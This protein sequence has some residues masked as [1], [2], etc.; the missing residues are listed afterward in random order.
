MNNEEVVK[1][2]S[3]SQEGKKV[4][5]EIIFELARALNLWIRDRESFHKEIE[6]SNL[7]SNT[8]N[9]PQDFKEEI[10]R[11]IDNNENCIHQLYHTLHSTKLTRELSDIIRKCENL[12]CL[13]GELIPVIND[14][15]YEYINSNIDVFF[16]VIDS[17]FGCHKFNEDCFKNILFTRISNF[18]KSFTA[19]IYQFPIVVFNLDREIT[20][21]DNVKLIPLDPLSLKLEEIST[22]NETRIHKINFFLEVSVKTKCS[23]KLSLQLAEKSRDTTY[24]IL[25]LLGTRI[26]PQAIPLLTSSDRVKDPFLFYRYGPNRE[27]LFNATTRN[28]PYYQFH[29]KE[30][31]NEFF[32]SHNKT[33]SL[34]NIAFEIVELILM[35]NFSQERVVERFE[36]ALL[37][38][39][40]A[41]TE[42]IPFQ[43][44]QKLVSSLEALVNFHEENTT[45]TFKRRITNLHITYKGIDES[46]TDKARQLYD[47][48]SKIIHGSSHYETFSFCIV[49]F[50]SETLLRAI[51]FFS[52]FGFE[53]TKIKKSLPTFLDDIPNRVSTKAGIP[54][55]ESP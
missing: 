26:S 6:N 8:I 11:R 3:I 21:S 49:S 29:S 9:P 31:W 40:D 44:V 43:Q 23:S 46:I 5:Q 4:F 24:N 32:Q 50:C 53:K 22:L 47:A 27:K 34:I 13:G 55:E 28:L 51:Y 17:N 39:G 52:I 54:N 15:A 38:Y 42:H 25:K 7:F 48:R 10:K 18:K 33:G 19:S 16:S 12:N 41:V 30:F 37:W 1:L 2:K 20:L 35:P 14:M 36:R 45:E